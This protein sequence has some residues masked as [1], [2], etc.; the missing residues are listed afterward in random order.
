MT[1]FL[2]DDFVGET[3]DGHLHSRFETIQSLKDDLAKMTSISLVEGK[4]LSIKRKEKVYVVNQRNH[5][6]AKAKFAGR[7]HDFESTYESVEY[8]IQTP[9]GF[10]LKYAR[11]SKGESKID[12]KPMG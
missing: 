3:P 5:L 9:K 4:L 12:G 2:T 1:A 6:K 7:V 11:E 10:R 8:W